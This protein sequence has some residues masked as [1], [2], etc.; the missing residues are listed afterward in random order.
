MKMSRLKKTDRSTDR[1][2]KQ[3]LS[4]FKYVFDK[5]PIPE[6]RFEVPIYEGNCRLALQDFFLVFSN[7]Y[8]EPHALLNPEGYRR[9]GFFLKRGYS[10]DFFKSL[11]T[12]SVIYAEK[13]R[14][15]KSE[16]VDKSVKQ[17]DTEEVYIVALHTAVYLRNIGD[18]ERSMFPSEIAIGFSDKPA[19][20]HATALEG[21]TC[22]WDID[23]FLRYYKPIAAKQFVKATGAVPHL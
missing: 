16:P 5:G 21:S 19:I 7:T 12:G 18:R 9:T 2:P 20:W 6:S 23:K 1:A 17:F 11:T 14:N 3:R 22:L 13:I 8:F 4:Y 10:D 15:R